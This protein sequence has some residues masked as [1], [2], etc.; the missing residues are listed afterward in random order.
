[1]K[2]TD[3][4]IR[5]AGVIRE[6]QLFSDFSRTVYNIWFDDNEVI[7]TMSIEELTALYGMI[8]NFINK[9]EGGQE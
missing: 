6:E 8:G 3:K 2:T 5:K 7:D 1:M 9:E 4:P